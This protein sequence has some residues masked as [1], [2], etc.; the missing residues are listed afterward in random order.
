MAIHRTQVEST[1]KA[2]IAFIRTRITLV[3]AVSRLTVR[4]TKAP[5]IRDNSPARWTWSGIVKQE[6][7]VLTAGVRICTEAAATDV[8]TGVGEDPGARSQI[9]GLGAKAEV[10]GRGLGFGVGEAAFG[11]ALGGGWRDGG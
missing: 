5:R 10:R 3:C 1:A 2:F 8:A 9:Y 4:P 11:A 6:A 7:G